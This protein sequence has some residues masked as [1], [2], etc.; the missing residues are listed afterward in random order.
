M[1]VISFGDGLNKVYTSRVMLTEEHV[2]AAFSILR[3]TAVSG[4][5]FLVFFLLDLFLDAVAIDVRRAR[6]PR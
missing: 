6:K 3:I 5:I 2:E 4:G 1:C